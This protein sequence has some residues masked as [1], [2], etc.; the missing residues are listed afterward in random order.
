MDP[1][2]DGLTPDFGMADSGAMLVWQERQRRARSLRMLMMF[3]MMLMLMDGEDSQNRRKRS[4]Q[5]LRKRQIGLQFD[6]LPPSVYYSRIE[7]DRLITTAVKEN[8]QS[9]HYELLKK[10][11]GRDIENEIHSL[12][13]QKLKDEI[14][15]GTLMMNNP[16]GGDGG[17]QKKEKSKII[18]ED[19]NGSDE[20][21]SARTW[22]HY[23]RN[24]TGYYRGIW[25]TVPVD[26]RTSNELDDAELISRLHR[27]SDKFTSA[28]G[29]PDYSIESPR[30][31]TADDVY[32]WSDSVLRRRGFDAAVLL[33]PHGVQFQLNTTS[34]NNS[35]VE[36]VGSTGKDSM[37]GLRQQASVKSSDE[38]PHGFTLSKVAGRAAFQLYR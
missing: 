7:E 34:K 33:L 31:V 13:Q 27:Q 20:R 25:V 11:G 1:N 29:E 19:L 5:N 35:T 22:F 3:L 9:R 2:I 8:M 6:S 15:K 23:P 36:H 16:D 28:I 38:N 32:P 37:Q 17:K 4:I 30:N 14:E 24:A 21:E 26:N 10:N 12:I 18:M